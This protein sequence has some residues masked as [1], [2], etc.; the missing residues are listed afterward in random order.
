[1]KLLILLP[2]LALGC[3]QEETLLFTEE[4]AQAMLTIGPEE[5]KQARTIT[6]GPN[7]SA[8][9][10]DTLTG[11][12]TFAAGLDPDEASRHFWKI[13]KIAVL[14]CP[15]KDCTESGKQEQQ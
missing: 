14:E 15:C 10:L 2:I 11:N 13:L 3:S 7:D 5:Q 1:M 4:P 9:Y 12:V 6:I 8:V